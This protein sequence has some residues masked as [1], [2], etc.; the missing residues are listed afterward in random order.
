MTLVK[1]PG[2]VG[3]KAARVSS[4]DS[5]AIGK[6]TDTNHLYSI[7]GLAPSDYDKK[8]INIY[9][10]TALYNNDFMQMLNKSTPFMPE[11]DVWKWDV[12]VPYM[13]PTIVDIPATTAALVKPGIDEQPFQFVLDRNVYFKHNYVTPDR[14]YGPQWYILQDPTPY[15][16]AWLY[17]ATLVTNNPMTDFVDASLWLKPGLN[18]VPAGGSGLGEFDEDL[19]GLRDL[20]SKICLYESMAAEDGISHSVTGWADAMGISKANDLIVYYQYRLNEQ[21]K[22]VPTGNLKWEPF[23]ESMIRRQMLDNK[24]NAMI[25]SKPGTV[26]TNGTNQEVKKSIEG[27][28]Y[29]IRNNGNYHDYPRGEFSLNIFRNAFGDLF[30][31]RVEMSKRKVKVYTNEAGF[32]V[33]EKANQQDLMNAGFTVVADTRFIEGSGR[34]MVLNY[35]FNS[36]VTRETGRVELVHLAQLD[37]PQTN[38]EFGQN[39]KSTPIFLVFDISP[40]G[41]GSL[42]SNCREV[43]LKGMPSMRWGYID[44]T[45]HHLGFAASQGMSSAN[46]FDGYKIWYKDR[47]DLFVEDLSRMVLIEETPQF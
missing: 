19:P 31:R 25:W 4:M 33:F 20:G 46:M 34:N 3:F 40:N 8:V 5:R 2:F 13:F 29:K 43:R 15:N 36:M 44:G 14:R 27:L 28:Y 30:Y 18:I 26:R 17:T 47:Y 11:T 23:I 42:G 37:E 7:R 10:Q 22:E 32:D 39:K 1:Q 24:V 41:D 16:G 21:G 9:T 6:L 35:A 45:Y 38:L 12:H